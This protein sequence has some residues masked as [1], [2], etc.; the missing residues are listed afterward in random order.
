MRQLFDPMQKIRLLHRRPSDAGHLSRH[1]TA[2]SNL[3]RIAKA[4]ASP[5][6]PALS[7]IYQSLQDVSSRLSLWTAL[8]AIQNQIQPD[9]SPQSQS[10]RK[11]NR[12]R[13]TEDPL[14]RKQ[15]QVN[16]L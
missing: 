8:P 4:S 6:S 10:I 2:N 9:R 13:P 15:T 12:H 5:A 1:S 7:S 11:D 14:K 3:L 16:A